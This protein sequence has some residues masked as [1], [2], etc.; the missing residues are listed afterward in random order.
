[1]SRHQHHSPL[2]SRSA[3][4]PWTLMLVALVFASSS[5]AQV[6]WNHFSSRGAH[7]TTYDAGANSVLAFGG[8]GSRG[9][10][11]ELQAYDGTGWSA[12]SSASSPPP[13]L[14]GAMAHFGG[15]NNTIVFGGTVGGSRTNV[16][17]R[18]NGNNWSQQNPPVTPTPRSGH[19]MAYMPSI[20]RIVLFGGIDT[21]GLLDDTWEWNGLT[22][23]QKFPGTHPSATDWPDMALDSTS[24]RLV[25]YSGGFYSETAEYDGTNW[26]IVNPPVDPGNFF[27]CMATA[28]G[29]G[30]VLFGGVDPASFYPSRS[31][32]RYQGG[33]WTRVSGFQAPHPRTDASMTYDATRNRIVLHG[34]IYNELGISDTI[35]GDTWEWDGTTWTQGVGAGSP[36]AS[37]GG[38]MAFDDSRQRL[39]LHGGLIGYSSQGSWA[40]PGTFAWT[41]GEWSQ[42]A[43]GPAVE[44]AAMA[45]DSH[46]DRLVLVGG[47][48]NDLQSYDVYE[49]NGTGWSNRGNGPGAR[50]EPSICYDEA[51]Q[52]T[53]VFGGYYS[54]SS[55]P[56]NDTWEYDGVTW[57][58]K[59]PATVP[60][61]TNM[62]SLCYDTHLQRPLLVSGGVWTW[63]G[64]NWILLDATTPPGTGPCVYD[65]ARRRIVRPSGHEWTP[66]GWITRQLAAPPPACSV[67]GGFGYDDVTGESI[68]FG[69]WTTTG[70]IIGDIWRYGVTQPAVATP[71]G[72]GCPDQNS[73][74]FSLT[75]TGMPPWI[76]TTYELAVTP[77]PTPVLSFGELGTS[78]TQ[79]GTISLP[80][81]L[82]VY[83]MPGCQ[84][85]IEPLVGLVIASNDW[86]IP[87]PNATALVATPLFVQA[88]PFASYANAAGVISTN[89]LRLQF[90]SR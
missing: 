45:Y 10:L 9:A 61:G 78:D 88:F 56:M 14:D 16:T 19:A 65:R 50:L 58:Q 24:Q 39:L 25:M 70:K 85:L 31:L 86:N 53:L 42:I 15:Q 77:A 2:I 43:S 33:S 22:W 75:E 55:G 21:G 29:G 47:I 52:R 7:M 79:W 41:N 71:F 54:S 17:W 83:G 48:I 20:N 13:T 11:T 64:S 63:N 46:R 18:F 74:I 37:T 40:V 26:T 8:R 49:F 32:W 73:T 87:I 80:F 66:Q 90:G 1:M 69:G 57:V 59:N 23:T 62:P 76:G 30:V 67:W 44:R 3:G 28:P 72:S 60:P 81:D 89:A 68:L 34:G 35:L 12:P 51:R 36:T 5:V 4:I 84:Q 82:G 38:A 27:G 6:E